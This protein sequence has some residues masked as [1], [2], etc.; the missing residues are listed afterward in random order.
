M[1]GTKFS[2]ILFTL[3]LSP[4]AFYSTITISFLQDKYL[5]HLRS[6]NQNPAGDFKT[7]NNACVKP[8]VELLLF[9]LEE[10]RDGCAV[11]TNQ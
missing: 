6:C 10:I 4:Y 1:S 3:S 5:L 8:L 7:M 2:L 11:L 9:V